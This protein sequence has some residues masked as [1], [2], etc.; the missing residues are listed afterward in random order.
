MIHEA[1]MISG[2]ILLTIPSVQYGGYFLLRVLSGKFDKANFT[3]FQK[4]MFRAGHAHAGV[5]LILSIVCEILIDSI[6]YDDVWK[7]VLRSAFPIAVIF[8]SGGFFAAAGKGIT[9]PTKGIVLLYIGLFLLAISLV[10]LGVGLI[11]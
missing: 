9:R 5:L 11:M 3:D 1:K 7:G 10:I 4:S 8:I 2:I 6:P